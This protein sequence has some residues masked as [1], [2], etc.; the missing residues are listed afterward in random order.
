M[1]KAIRI[2]RGTADIQTGCRGV[3]DQPDAALWQV[4]PQLVRTHFLHA[5]VRGDQRQRNRG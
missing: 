4:Y 5:Q 1:L 2:C 3:Q